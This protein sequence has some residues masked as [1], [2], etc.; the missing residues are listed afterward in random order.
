MALRPVYSVQIMA[1]T[2]ALPLNTVVVP[3]DSRIIVRDI[4]AFCESG[5]TGF[6][7]SFENAAGGNL[8][9]PV[10][11]AFPAIGNWQWRG[12]QVFN[13]GESITIKV[14]SGTWSIQMSGYE[15]SLP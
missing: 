1:L 13:P 2:P 7:F 6:Q 3:A 15:L 10:Q 14:F 8:W 5:G 12:R 11:N 9:A 4:D